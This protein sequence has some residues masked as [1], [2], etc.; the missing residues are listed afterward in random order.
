M[1]D[2]V[3]V[4]GGPAGLATALHARRAGLTVTVLE[5]RRAPTDKACGEGL[6]PGAVA[7]LRR[8]GVELEG[9]HSLRGIRWLQGRHEATAD[10][11]DGPGLGLRRT[12]LHA[13]LRQ[14]VDAA[15]IPVVARPADEVRQDADSVTAGGV[16]GRWLVAADGLHSPIRHRLGLAV[17]EPRPA[18]TPI[19]RW[20]GRHPRGRRAVRYGLRAHYPVAPWSD[21]VEVY[22]SGDAEAYVTPVG[23]NLVGVAILSARR[24]PYA[25]QL[26]TFSGL[27]DRLQD[28]A[29]VTAVRGAG[30]FRQRARARVSGRVLL[31]GDAAGYV[32]ALTGEGIALACA[33]AAAAVDCIIANRPDAYE[34]RWRAVTRS[35]RLITGTLVQVRNRPLLAPLLVPAAAAMPP[36]FEAAVHRLAAVR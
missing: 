20:L 9:G 8:L 6:M 11:R 32:D 22:W 31:V 16:S 15:A 7:A 25:E 21:H 36:V 26:A 17:R 18:T 35:Y 34:A 14:A 3:V 29:P 4:G 33:E 12:D 24:E 30:P 27:T 2:V 10:F 13:A 23:P 5:P 1:I 28:S 19:G